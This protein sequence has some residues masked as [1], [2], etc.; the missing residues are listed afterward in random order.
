MIQS[1]VEL[2]Q[3]LLSCSCT[4][5]VID[6]F[7]I[8]IQISLSNE[9]RLILYAPE[10]SINIHSILYFVCYPNPSDGRQSAAQKFKQPGEVDAYGFRIYQELLSNQIKVN[11]H[12]LNT[13]NIKIN[14]QNL[15]LSPI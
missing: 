6:F 13:F 2:H 10:L 4:T 1:C 7:M 15:E 8:Y 12:C 3:E 11:L 14:I 9:H 5:G